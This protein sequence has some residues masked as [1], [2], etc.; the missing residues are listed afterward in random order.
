MTRAEAEADTRL[1]A[2][3]KAAEEAK[4]KAKY[5]EKLRIE[6]EEK[7]RFEAGKSAAAKEKAGVTRQVPEKTGECECC[8]R[9]DI[10]ES[11]LVKI[12]S[13]QMFCKDCLKELRG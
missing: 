10:K 8:G 12:D 2:H 6:A 9:K 11:D 7:A 13:G 3:K 4:S 5:Q 1:K